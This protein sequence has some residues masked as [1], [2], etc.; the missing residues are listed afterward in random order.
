MGDEKGLSTER[1]DRDCKLVE[2]GIVKLT[3]QYILDRYDFEK[4]DFEIPKDAPPPPTGKAPKAGP[5]VQASNGRKQFT[6][7]QEAVETLVDRSLAKARSPVPMA[8]IR[9]AIRASKTPEQMVDKLAKVFGSADPTEFR[10]LVER[11]LFAA[12]V[13]GYSHADAE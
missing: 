4:G 6:P 10:E 3:E 8:K 2:S 7:D 9:A 13:M 11:A 1:A 5:P 12:D